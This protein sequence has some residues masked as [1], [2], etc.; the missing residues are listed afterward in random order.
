MVENIVSMIRHDMMLLE[1]DRLKP[2]YIVLD[3]DTYRKVLGS[4]V[5]MDKGILVP[6][7]YQARPKVGDTLFWLP[8]TVT[9]G[10]KF[11]VEVVG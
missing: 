7:C 6:A 9:T 10:T 4:R 8:I 11:T 5:L 1:R 2:K 3:K